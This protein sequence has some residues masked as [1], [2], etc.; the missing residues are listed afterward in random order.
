MHSDSQTAI[1]SGSVRNEAQ[2]LAQADLWP[3]GVSLV[4]TPLSIIECQPY[5]A[6]FRGPGG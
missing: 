5:A 6:Y 4:R 1:R 2:S 3:G